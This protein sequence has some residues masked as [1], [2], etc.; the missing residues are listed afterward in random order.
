[1]TM[2]NNNHKHKDHCLYSK[3]VAHLN[4]PISALYFSWAHYF[5]IPS[6]HWLTVLY[7]SLS[8]LLLAHRRS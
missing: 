4:A 1:M 6:I 8:Y 7:S 2:A 3:H 5:W